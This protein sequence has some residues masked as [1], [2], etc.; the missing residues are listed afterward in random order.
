MINK[1]NELDIIG[2]E[3]NPVK[4]YDE[5]KQ[6]FG[7]MLMLEKSCNILTISIDETINKIINSIKYL[8]P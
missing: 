6:E 3:S 5:G 4:F 8:I 1:F 7:V 2:Y